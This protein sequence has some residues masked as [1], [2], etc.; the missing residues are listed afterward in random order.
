MNECCMPGSTF[1]TRPLYTLPTTLR[2]RSRSTKISATRSSSRM[3]TIVSW[4]LEETIISLFIHELPGTL[5][6]LP[7][8]LSRG[9]LALRS[10]VGGPVGHRCS[11]AALVRE[12]AH[13]YV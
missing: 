11:G 13:A 12:S 7:R 9:K 5:A 8:D 2:W 3:A 1:D 10:R 6:C 4:P